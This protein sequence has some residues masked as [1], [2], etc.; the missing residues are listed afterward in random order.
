[1]IFPTLLNTPFLISVFHPGVIP[2]PGIPSS[3]I[4]GSCEGIFIHVVVQIDVSREA[5]ITRNPFATILVSFSFY[6]S[7][8]L[9]ISSLMHKNHSLTLNFNSQFIFSLLLRL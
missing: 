1:M 2:L 9:S 4:L 5:V 7:F 8:I 6:A 3:G